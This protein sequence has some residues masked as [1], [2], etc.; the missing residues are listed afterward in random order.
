[1]NNIRL[2]DV[3]IDFGYITQDQLQA[4]LAYQ[5]EHKNLRVGQALQELGYVNERQVLEALAQRLHLRVIDFTQINADIS[6]VEKVPRELAQKYDMLPIAI[7]GRSLVIA[8]N[9]PLNYYALEDIRQLTSM[10][11]EIVL[12]ELEPLRR[13]IQYYY[14][15]VRARKAASKANSSD[16]AAARSEEFAVDMTEEGGDTDAPI[17]RLL[18]SLVQRAATTGASDIHIE[19]FEGE[20]KVR[21][22]IDGVIID[23]V[24]LQRAL[25]QPLIARIKIMA[26]LDIAERRLPQDGHFRIRVGQSEYVNIRVSLLPTVFGE[27]A[28]LRILA[29]AGQVDH[30]SHFGMDDESYARFLPMLNSPNGIIYITGPTGSGK[31]TT[32][33][34]VLE[35]LS[36]RQVNISTVEDPVEKNVPSI[37]QT[38]VNPVAGLT[39]E[40]G[41]RA[42]LRQDPD[43]IM[44]GETRDGETAGIS[45]RAAITGHLVLSTLHTNDAVSSIVRLADMG[46]DHYLIANSLV[47]LVAQRLM[48]KVCPHCGREVAVTPQ[49][50]ALLGKDITTI[51]RGTGCTHCN[52]TGYRGRIAVHE[53]VTI[54]RNIRRMISRGAEIEEIEAY[55]RE[56]QGMRS[57]KEKGLELVKQ[58][59]TTPEELLRIAYYA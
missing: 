51:K 54:D 36:H 5:K 22:R 11:P 16:M 46:I 10:E 39:F 13:S 23:Y 1:M 55:A 58:G 53:I 48:R 3:L 43:I 44:V 32:L 12:A 28:V 49:E 57:L 35:Y 59:V 42:L 33:Y 9:D 7:N 4:A 40:S 27:K 45:V 2:G 47:G 56:Q 17:I 37:N 29:T 25:H 18:N 38:Q 50:Q 19:P 31:S 41:L 24:T 34:M 6:A 20:T 14:A 21:M 30:A 52:G 26:N 8:A 15:E